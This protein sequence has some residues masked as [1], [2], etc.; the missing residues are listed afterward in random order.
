[1]M[2]PEGR[3]INNEVLKFLE[4]AQNELLCIAAD[5]GSWDMMG[6]CDVFRT[7]RNLDEGESSDCWEQGYNGMKLKYTPNYANIVTTGVCGT[8]SGSSSS[9][10][11]TD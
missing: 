10:G 11:S 5:T 3:E 1:M 4:E 2:N 9:S 7:E 6:H 8:D